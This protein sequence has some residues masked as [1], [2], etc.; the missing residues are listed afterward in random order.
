MN[1]WSRV[2]RQIPAVNSSTAAWGMSAEASSISVQ[3]RSS[4]VSRKTERQQQPQVW[5]DIIGK[6]EEYLSVNGLHT[7]SYL[8]EEDTLLYYD[9][10]EV[11]EGELIEKS[12]DGG[13]GKGGEGQEEDI[14]EWGAKPNKSLSC[15]TSAVLALK[16]PLHGTVMLARL[17]PLGDRRAEE[18]CLRL[19]YRCAA[20]VIQSALPGAGPCRGT[21]RSFWTQLQGLAALLA[22]FRGRGAVVA[23]VPG[24]WGEH[25]A[26]PSW[27]GLAAVSSRGPFSCRRA[28]ALMT[29]ISRTAWAAGAGSVLAIEVIAGAAGTTG[30]ALSRAEGAWLSCGVPIGHSAVRQVEEVSGG[31]RACGFGA[32]W[33]CGCVGPPLGPVA[34]LS[35]RRLG[36]AREMD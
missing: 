1:V 30:L 8:V 9:E 32:R 25:G 17:A 36:R 28:G 19:D 14:S 27:T 22:G 26:L 7:R 15:D 2:A 23:V 18:C 21:A 34:G 4:V 20:A 29:W 12:V 10:D 13:A 31:D 35:F 33:S 3:G 11:E 16:L 24:A 6:E 5:W